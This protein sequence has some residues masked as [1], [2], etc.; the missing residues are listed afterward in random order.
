MAEPAI[1]ST[2]WRSA[3]QVWKFTIG[4]GTGQQRI[5]MPKGAKLLTVQVQN[6]VPV[7]WALCAEEA[8]LVDRKLWA[9]GTG[10]A[11]PRACPYVA[12]LQ[13]GAAVLHFFDLGESPLHTTLQDVGVLPH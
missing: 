4:A 6:G 13:I 3:L 2:T 10:D 5:K 8:P 12:T 7:L 11:L 9:Y 1:D